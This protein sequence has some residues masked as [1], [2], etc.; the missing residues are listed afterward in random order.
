[1]VRSREKE[2][3]FKGLAREPATWPKLSARSQ[4]KL[5]MERGWNNFDE[6]LAHWRV[7]LPALGDAFVDGRAEVDPVDPRRACEYCDLMTFCRISS[8]SAI[9]ENGEGAADE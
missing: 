6:I 5:L 1:M 8:P 7:A 2:C 9:D 4:E 3:A